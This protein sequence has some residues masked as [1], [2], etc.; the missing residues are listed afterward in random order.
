[1]L[2][3][4]YWSK[5]N[6]LLDTLSLGGE[7]GSWYLTCSGY[8]CRCIASIERMVHQTLL[9]INLL[10]TIVNTCFANYFWLTESVSMQLKTSRH[11]KQM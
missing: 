8:L 10:P 6:H 2:E 7:M 9:D 4:R 5:G 1:M 11:A 3:H